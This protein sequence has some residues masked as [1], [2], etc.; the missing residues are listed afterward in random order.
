MLNGK[1][2]DSYHTFAPCHPDLGT[3]M[4]IHHKTLAKWFVIQY[5]FNDILLFMGEIIVSESSLP[6]ERMV[7]FI[8][9]HHVMTLAT[10]S[11][12]DTPWCASCFYSY[13]EERNWFVFTS[14]DDTRHGGEMAANPVVAVCIAL[15]TRITGRIRG[16]QMT[17]KSR[18][19]SGDELSVASRSFLKQFPIAMLKKT[20]LWI[21]EP[22]H[23]KMTDN[24][25]GFGK[26][27][28]WNRASN[29]TQ[30]DSIS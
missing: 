13:I 30:S 14:D 5:C 11:E 29:P 18:K 21:F 6:E 22:D 1:D 23:I 15:E 24:R 27:L 16:V 9:E 26:K 17:G 10:V 4:N 19:A 2:S 20:T 28:V 8:R 7:S 25:L 3:G 12:P